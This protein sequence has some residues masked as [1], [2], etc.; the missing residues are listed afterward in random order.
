MVVVVVV[1]AV[2][3]AERCNGTSFRV[4]SLLYRRPVGGYTPY[5]HRHR[6]TDTQTHTRA[7]TDEEEEEGEGLGRGRVVGRTAGGWGV[8][9]QETWPC[10]RRWSGAIH[11]WTIEGSAGRLPR[12]DATPPPLVVDAVLGASQSV[13]AV[14]PARSVGRS[15]R[16]LSPP[17]KLSSSRRRCVAVCRCVRVCD[18]SVSSAV[19]VCCRVVVVVSL[20][21][22]ERH[23]RGRL[24]TGNGECRGAFR[25][26]IE[27]RPSSSLVAVFSAS[28]L[29]AFFGLPG[30]VAARSNNNNGRLYI[31]GRRL[32]SL[33]RVFGCSA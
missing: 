6:H 8:V 12:L 28:S 31:F 18:T 14:L 20:A 25:L 19:C 2:A 21:T 33:S 15:V 27:L 22:L 7:H 10:R 17:K 32:F 30:D 5:T 3:V 24:P 11:R 1:V 9:C 16:L 26:K 29:A 4:W 13:L 23:L